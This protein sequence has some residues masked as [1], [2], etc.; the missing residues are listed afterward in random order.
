MTVVARAWLV[1]LAGVVAQPG[2]AIERRAREGGVGTAEPWA[3]GAGI[4]LGHPNPVSPSRGEPEAERQRSRGRRD[5]VAENVDLGSRQLRESAA[6]GPAT[7]SEGD[8]WR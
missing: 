3:H 6:N 1:F 8:R 5:V 2:G 7:Q 4:R